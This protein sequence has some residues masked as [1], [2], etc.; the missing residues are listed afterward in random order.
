MATGRN[1]MIKFAGLECC[2]TSGSCCVDSGSSNVHLRLKLCC[3]SGFSDDIFDYDF[4]RI[5][6]I[7]ILYLRKGNNEFEC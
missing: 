3:V 6:L 5:V 4:I 2:F 1:E 7:G